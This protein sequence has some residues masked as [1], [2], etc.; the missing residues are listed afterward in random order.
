MRA[1]PD[2]LTIKALSEQSQT[3]RQTIHYYL[4]R[5]VLP[6]PV[7][8]SRTSALYPK[9][10]IELLHLVKIA[11]E[12]KRLSLEEIRDLFRNSGY[13]AHLIRERLKQAGDG[14]SEKD[15]TIEDVRLRLDPPP[16]RSWVE[17]L[18][19]REL[20]EPE[21]N[22]KELL[23]TH[24]SAELMR[25]LWE[26]S[27]MGIPL[28]TFQRINDRIRTEADRETGPVPVKSARNRA[29]GG[30]L[31]AA[32][33]PVRSAREVRYAPLESVT[34]QSFHSPLRALV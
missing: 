30:R 32:C 16:P 14:A 5:G 12:K 6:E 8:V 33:S 9:S 17:E 1:S 23:F 3:H 31:F 19:K 28:D 10:S 27:R 22:R 15:L 25:G 18:V 24:S 4:R 7:R 11:Q 34:Q 2:L 26:G 29:E 21:P 13:K 20:V